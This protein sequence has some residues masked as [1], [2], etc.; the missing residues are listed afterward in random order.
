M[1]IVLFFL[2]IANMACHTTQKISN[3]PIISHVPILVNDSIAFAYQL[4]N[5][6]K[7]SRVP[8]HTFSAKYIIDLNNG[9]MFSTAHAHV[10]MQ[11]DSIIWVSIGAS[12]GI[13]AARILIT[14][15]S[16]KLYNRIQ[17]TVFIHPYTYLATMGIPFDFI[18]LQDAIIGNPIFI[19]DQNIKY[20]PSKMY[21]VLR[22]INDTLTIH[23]SLDTI[24]HHIKIINLH[25]DKNN[26]TINYVLDQYEQ[27]IHSQNPI[28]TIRKIDFLLNNGNTIDIKINNIKF[29]QSHNYP[30]NIPDGYTIN[31]Q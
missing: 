13:E 17:K 21:K 8:Y 29:E 15:D 10:R 28:S 18:T 16:V 11:K 20:I 2:W 5:R 27:D 26:R 12:V 6:I 31:P 23:Y 25:D 19:T 24:D 30:F 9:S 3:T 4:Y 22:C 1:Y 7:Q 14:P